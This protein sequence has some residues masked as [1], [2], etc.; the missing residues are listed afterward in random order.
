MAEALLSPW[1]LNAAI[2]SMQSVASKHAKPVGQF[3]PILFTPNLLQI[4]RFVRDPSN[5]CVAYCSDRHHQILTVFTK[6]AAKSCPEITGLRGA[7]IRADRYRF[8]KILFSGKDMLLLLTDSWK[9]IGAAGC[10][11]IG[12]PIDLNSLPAITKL[13]VEEQAQCESQAMPN[14]QPSNEIP[15]EVG[16]DSFNKEFP[17]CGIRAADLVIPA[18]QARVLDMIRL[19]EAPHTVCALFATRQRSALPIDIVEDCAAVENE[20]PVPTT[21]ESVQEPSRASKALAKEEDFRSSSDCADVKFVCDVKRTS[22]PTKDHTSKAAQSAS[23]QNVGKALASIQLAITPAVVQPTKTQAGIEAAVSTQSLNIEGTVTEAPKPNTFASLIDTSRTVVL[24]SQLNE[25][26]LEPKGTASIKT[27]IST[28]DN[29][30]KLSQKPVIVTLQASTNANSSTSKTTTV[31]AENTVNAPKVTLPST[32][33]ISTALVTSSEPVPVA[34]GPTN[35]V[36]GQIKSG[37][38]RVPETTWLP[39]G[40]VSIAPNATLLLKDSVPQNSKAPTKPF[41]PTGSNIEAAA[42][43]AHYTKMSSSSKPKK[44]K[45]SKSLLPLKTH[46]IVDLSDPPTQPVQASIMKNEH[47]VDRERLDTFLAHIESEKIKHSSLISKHSTQSAMQGKSSQD[48]AKEPPSPSMK[49]AAAALHEDRLLESNENDSPSPT[50]IMTQVPYERLA[51]ALIGG[52]PKQSSPHLSSTPAKYPSK[53]LSNTSDLHS[54][55]SGMTSLGS[56]LKRRSLLSSVGLY[57]LPDYSSW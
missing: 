18:E 33:P 52:S 23:A 13:L 38:L 36:A 12:T 16:H 20:A 4:I 54:L 37:F 32:G 3:Y 8:C 31:T 24:N 5:A 49:N 51:S 22:S 6:N 44:A 40:P 25:P 7:I 28:A 35:S 39:T 47:L 55:R 1:L 17:F 50:Q 42:N 56:A 21:R 14:T 26:S 45:T 10:N 43:V 41:P 9:E 2:S 48:V 15:I 53:R 46:P 19:D 30:A 29:M 27:H 57:G 11:T 34:K